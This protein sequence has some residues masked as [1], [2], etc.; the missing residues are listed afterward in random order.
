ML[1]Y[2]S[3][4][5]SLSEAEFAIYHNLAISKSVFLPSYF[6]LNFENP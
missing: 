3:D 5:R 6:F 2:S 1:L 4:F